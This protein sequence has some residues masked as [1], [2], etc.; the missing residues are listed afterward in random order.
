VCRMLER[1]WAAVGG[2][3][4]GW[5]I[6]PTPSLLALPSRPMAY[7]MM[8]K[9][10]RRQSG[11]GMWYLWNEELELRAEICLFGFG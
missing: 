10:A 5:Y 6:R 1:I 4:E 7:P 11:E 3:V 9:L 2:V 8:T